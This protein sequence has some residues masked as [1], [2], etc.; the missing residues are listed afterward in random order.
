MLVGTP[1]TAARN[2]GSHAVP[3]HAGPSRRAGILLATLIGT[4]LLLLGRMEAG[5]SPPYPL[6]AVAAIILV[7][8]LLCVTQL[9]VAFLLILAATPFSM[10]RVIPGT[11]SAL[12]IPTEP[13]LFVALAAWGLRSLVRRPRMFAQPGLTAALLLSLGVIGLTIIVSAYRLESFKAALN[14]TW[15]GLFGVFLLNNI[16]TPS[17]LRMLSWTLLLSGAALSLYSLVNVLVGHY[18]PL[19]G[20]WWG[21]PF[22]TEHGSFSAYL[23][24]VCAL[25]LGLAFEMPGPPKVL[26]ALVALLSGSQVILSMTRAAWLGLVGLAVFLAVIFWR[27]IFRP[28]NMVLMAAVILGVAGLVLASGATRRLERHAET[29]ADPTYVSNLERVNRWA[30]GYG[31]FRSAP[32]TGVGFGAFSAAYLSFRRIP[33]E[34]EQST[35]RMGVHSEYLKILAETGLLGLMAAAV[36]FFFVARITVRTIRR[37]RDP[38]LRGLAVGMAGG[39]VT[40][41]IHGIVNNY[42]AYDK[43]AVPVWTAVGVLGAIETLTRK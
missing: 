13:M 36:T 34:T 9:E 39:L 17:R 1:D 11:G 14:A 28:G 6:A 31:M 32:L 2:P 27:R 41:G 19:I 4:V 18:E 26:L 40:Y 15:Y 20:Y 21:E 25:A 5:A 7:F 12:Q 37:T 22:F 29:I 23:S 42:M 8:A 16:S 30:A 33:L 35:N 10:E 3:A 43:L 24:F 38:Y